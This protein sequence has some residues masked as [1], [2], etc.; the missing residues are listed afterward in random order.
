MKQLLP[1][2]L[3]LLASPLAARDLFVDNL[4]G[5][6]IER[7]VLDAPNCTGNAFAD[8]NLELLERGVCLFHRPARSADD[9]AVALGLL[10]Q[11]QTRGL[12]PVHQ[13]LAGLLSGLAQCDQAAAHLA[14]FRAS[15]NVNEDERTQFC[16]ARRGAQADLNAIRWNHALFDY[17]TGLAPRFSID[18]RLAEMSTCHMGP[19]D[20][21]LDA[22]CGLITNMTETEINAFVDDSVAAT[23]TTYFSGVESPITAMFSRKLKRAEGLLQSAV[24][25]IAGLQDTAAGVNAEYATLNAAYVE[26]R[27]TKMGP[28]YDSYRDA[29]LRATS[30]LDEFDRW[31]GGLFLTSENINLLPKITERSVEVQEELDRTTD[32]VFRDKAYGSGR[33][34]PPHRQQHAGKP[35]DGSDA[36]PGVFLRAHQPAGNGRGDPRLPQTGAGGQSLVHRG[37]RANHQRRSDGGFWRQPIRE[38]RRVVPGGRGGPGLYR[39][40]SGPGHR[41]HLPCGDAMIRLAFALLVLA[42]PAVAQDVPR[43]SVFVTDQD[44][45]VFVAIYGEKAVELRGCTGVSAARNLLQLAPEAEVSETTLARITADFGFGAQP[46]LPCAGTAFDADWP[47]TTPI[48]ADV[49]GSGN[50]Y[51]PVPTGGYVAVPARCTAIKTALAIRERLQLPGVLQGTMAPP[52][53]NDT[54]LAL[55]CAETVIRP[56]PVVPSGAAAGWT[57]HRFETFLSEDSTGD[58]IYVAR[59]LG[60]GGAPAYLPILRIDGRDTR[61]IILA[62]GLPML[63][64]EA[65]LARLFGASPDA[66]VTMLGSESVASLRDALYVDLC[67]HACAGYLHTPAAFLRPGLDLGLTELPPLTTSAELDRLGT[68]RAAVGFAEGR[69]LSFTGCADLTTAMGLVAADSADW[70]AAT[71]TALQADPAAGTGFDCRG[72][73][74]V[75]CTR[76]VPDGGSLTLGLFAPGADCAGKTDLR[77]ELPALVIAPAPLLL[78][79]LPFAR[80]AFVPAPGVARSRLVVTPGRLTTASAVCVL[81]GTDA[82]I[83]ASSLAQLSLTAIDLERKATDTA[84]EVVAVQAQGGR[85]VLQD[86]SIGALPEGSAPV[87]RGVNLCAADLYVTGTR[88]AAEAIAVQG[89]SARVMITG[90]QDMRASL[91]Q[92]R[93]GLL[94]SSQSLVRLHQ[95]DIAATSPI[96]LRGAELRASSSTLSPLIMAQPLGSAVQLER[97]SVAELQISSVAGFRCAASFVD[98]AS[99]LGLVLPGN[100]IARDNTF[101]ACGPGQ[102]SLIE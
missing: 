102:F 19:L 31:K 44:A 22:E 88:I 94:V 10:V 15:D 37:Q 58:T 82:L 25:G 16:A 5:Y 77:I 78:Q 52:D 83:A 18:A 71:A 36:V 40:G 51:L 50:Y 81:S 14:A 80:I 3:I 65:D 73:S 87:Q 9:T 35:H 79:N 23:I 53:L 76:R 59:N 90:S 28:I 74:A 46:G 17:A 32:L 43:L 63:E 12:P 47:A 11:A 95:T 21:S 8:P 100:D 72:S 91:T 26:A 61:D 33:R 56:D 85:I 54:V 6:S 48:W 64:V 66:P 7:R 2:A 24:A 42:L 86:V 27:D 29:I 98:A 30:I 38:H 101:S 4:A 20:P 70:F 1:L 62:G 57:L 45:D 96:V 75:T 13:Q 67:L 93:F 92:A 41:C 97:A 60:A 34:H 69:S 49:A 84:G 89:L 39:G 99:R 68:S 55:T